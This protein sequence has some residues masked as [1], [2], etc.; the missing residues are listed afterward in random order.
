MRYRRNMDTVHVPVTS[1]WYHFFTIPEEHEPLVWDSVSEE[2]YA[3]D[4]EEWYSDILRDPVRRTY[5]LVDECGHVHMIS[6]SLIGV[7]DQTTDSSGRRVIHLYR[8]KDD[9]KR[10]LFG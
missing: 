1:P 3:L 10:V 6:I 5:P 7:A 2:D 4:P 8:S 9:F